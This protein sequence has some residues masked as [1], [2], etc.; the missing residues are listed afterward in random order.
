[1]RAFLRN[2]FFPPVCVGCRELIA[3]PDF[4]R[5]APYLCSACAAKWERETEEQCGICQRPVGQCVCVTDAMLSAR[6]PLFRKVLFYRHGTRDPIQNRMV[7]RIK[8]APDR[9]TVRF[10][11][12]QMA[13]AVRELLALTKWDPA[14]CALVPLPRGKE[15]RLAT[16]TDQAEALAR[17]LGELTGLRVA[18]LIL[19]APRTG[20]EQ[21]ELT[22]AERKKNA[23]AVFRL[24]NRVRLPRSAHLLLVDDIVTTGSSM[25]ASA[26]LLRRAGY[27]DFVALAALSDDANRTTNEK[28]PVIDLKER[29]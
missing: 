28:Q 23:A 17:S 21:K 15:K 9:R 14:N 12:E 6:I 26:K 22:A 4:K 3:I 20:S 2:L 5:E 24:S 19:R 18:N 27:S 7:Y 13:P 16:G 11:A 25:A 10:F 8:E 29:R 1:M